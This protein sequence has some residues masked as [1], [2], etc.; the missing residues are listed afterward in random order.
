MVVLLFPPQQ[1]GEIAAA[2]DKYKQHDDEQSDANSCQDDY[3]ISIF[4]CFS[5]TSHARE[6]GCKKCH[7][8]G[9]LS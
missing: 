8:V 1:S 5:F 4:F 6:E 9:R 7:Q 2:D 3:P